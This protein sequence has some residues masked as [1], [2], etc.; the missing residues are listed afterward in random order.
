MKP[1]TV[2]MSSARPARL[3]ERERGRR[4]DHDLLNGRPRHSAGQPEHRRQCGTK[5]FA[6]WAVAAMLAG[7]FGVQRL[8]FAGESEMT[9][10][11]SGIVGPLA[12]TAAPDV[13]LGRQQARGIAN[14]PVARVLSNAVTG[15]NAFMAPIVTGAI[16]SSGSISN[17]IG[18]TT[19]LVNSGLNSV[20]QQT[21]SITIAP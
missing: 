9:P 16:T 2:G 6:I 10:Q 7:A 5:T 21:S 1:E 17:N 20:V 12:G 18:S 4:R 15:A 13:E 8:C 19:G 3:D 14:F 11:A